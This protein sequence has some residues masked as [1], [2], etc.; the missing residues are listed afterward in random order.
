[1]RRLTAALL[2]LL[3]ILSLAACSG[4]G[5]GSK[6]LKQVSLVLDWYPNAVHSFIYVAQK[7]GYFKAEGLDV[8]IKMP[9]ENPTDGIKLVGSGKD[10]FALYYQPDVLMARSEGIPIVSVAAVVRQPLNAITAPVG[11]GISRPKDLEGKTVGYPSIPLNLNIVKTMVKADGGDPAKVKFQDIGWDLIPAVASKKVDAISGGY[12]NHEF[13]MFQKEGHKVQYFSPKDFGV[14][15]YY[16]LVLITGEQTATKEMATIEAIWRALSKGFEKTKA[17][18]KAA[19]DVLAASASKEAPLDLEIE[20]QSMAMLLPMMEAGGAK[21]GAQT[22]AD[23][24]KVLDW[25][26][27]Q[28]VVKAGLKPADA[29]RNIVK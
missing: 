22:E 11:T 21:F 27:A 26:T 4:S 5:S 12:I 23:W 17:D 2:S 18:P 6:E 14:P 13:L 15:N 10:T 3:L 9:A 24:Q 8:T 1:M 16:E 20:T 28:G 29:F 19:L 25:M 7:E